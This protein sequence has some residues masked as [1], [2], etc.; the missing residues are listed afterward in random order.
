MNL[1]FQ[2]EQILQPPLRLID[3]EKRDGCCFTAAWRS[4]IIGGSLRRPR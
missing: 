2:E 3:E 1:L 4:L